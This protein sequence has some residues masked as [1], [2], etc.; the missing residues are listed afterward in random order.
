MA[1]DSESRFDY[2][3]D[4]GDSPVNG[5]SVEVQVKAAAEVFAEAKAAAQVAYDEAVENQTHWFPCGFAWVTVKPARGSFVTWCKAKGLGSKAYGGGWQFW[6]S[7]V[8]NEM[9]T[10]NQGQCME[11]KYA[12]CRAFAEVLKANGLDAYADQRMD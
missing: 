12:A 2:T 4:V 10:A 9:W 6:S 5:G 11:L 3:E 1:L 7:E 8:V